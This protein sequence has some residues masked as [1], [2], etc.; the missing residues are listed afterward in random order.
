ME[1]GSFLRTVPDFP[2]QGINFIDITPLILEPKAFRSALD[3]L[4]GF[5]DTLSFDIIVS[6]EARGFIFG[7]P[8]AAR[9]GVPFV[10]VRKPGK[11]PAATLRGEY[12]LEYGRTA[13]EIHTDAVKPGQRAL[14]IDDLLATGG[15]V[16]AA[17]DLVERLGGQVAGF[18]FLVELSFL[19]GRSDLRDRPVYAVISLDR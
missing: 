6:P 3:E 13:L 1:L 14:V 19:H 18:G 2:R 7:A 8:L 16:G 4:K 10:P 5:A 12:Q 9:L 17:R 11:L 15:T